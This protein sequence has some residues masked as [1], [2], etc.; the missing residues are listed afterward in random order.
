MNATTQTAPD[1]DG[2]LPDLL[3]GVS[4]ADRIRSAARGAGLVAVIIILF[5][6]FTIARPSFGSGD[7]MVAILL[8]ASV[9]GV[10][11]IGQTY[12]LLTGGI[13]LSI[14]SIVA[15]SAISA[16]MFAHSMP[17]PVAILGGIAV[18]ALAGLANGL[19]ITLTGITPFVVTLGTMSIYSGVALIIAGG[20]AV[21]DI[22]QLFKDLLAGRM[23]GVPI[24][25][26]LVIAFAVGSAL[27]MKFTR[28]GEY[29]IAVG[30]S[31]QTARLAGINV[32]GITTG[33]YVL[34]GAGAGLAGAILVARLGAADPTIGADLLL[35][36]IAATVM[37]GTKLSGGEGSM[38]G[39]LFGAVL[40]A[41]LT[42]GLTAL[43]VQAFYQQVAV[44]AAIIIALLVD[45]IARR[46]RT[47]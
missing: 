5:V 17:A 30:G 10:M 41:T 39:A 20:R 8:Q 16:G 13:D 29:L 15:V 3:G 23:V 40:I 27:V 36:A 26:V 37:G 21:Y 25:I 18:G 6:A 2:A 33:A 34:S 46:E 19:L 1:V 22:P 9:V 32:K 28:F 44:G 12:V 7:N 11:A 45:R 31:A 14:G 24:P 38:F 35:T 42:A 47:A 4:W 43:N